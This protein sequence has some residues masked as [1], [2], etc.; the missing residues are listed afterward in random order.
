MLPDILWS[1]SQNDSFEIWFVEHST[2]GV[3]P[4]FRNYVLHEGKEEKGF[5][6]LGILLSADKSNIQYS[7]S[8]R[9]MIPY[10]H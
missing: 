6:M 10:E 4:N 7:N 2:D 8:W 9:M 3:I 5:S 1:K